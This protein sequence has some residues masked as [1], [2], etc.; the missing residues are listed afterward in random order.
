MQT[1]QS[2]FPATGEVI[3]E[4][5]EG[6]VDDYREC[7]AKARKAWNVW[8]DV[9]APKRGE[10]VRQIGVALRE[11]LEPLGKLVSMEMGKLFS[12]QLNMFLYNDTTFTLR[13]GK[14]LPEGIGEVQEYVD[15]CDYA[16]GLSRMFEGKV[17]PSERPDHALLE[18]WNPLGTIGVISAF[19]FPVAV[20]GW[21]NA[22]ALVELFLSYN[23]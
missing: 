13:I 16:V 12:F 22:L 8:A 11:K 6:T 7:V 4:V 9:P 2:I 15:I 19:N 10:I 14:I 5:C 21:N 1:V 18:M 20:Y 3:A 17:I 23:I